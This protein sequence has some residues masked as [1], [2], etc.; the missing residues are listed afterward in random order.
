MTPAK[1]KQKSAVAVFLS[2]NSYKNVVTFPFWEESK[3]TSPIH[4]PLS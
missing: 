3:R 2:A 1:Y 4:I